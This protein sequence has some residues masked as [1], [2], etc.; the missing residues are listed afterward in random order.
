MENLLL[1]DLTTGNIKGSSSSGKKVTSDSN[2]NLYIQ[3]NS[4]SKSNY[5]IIKDSLNAFFL[6][7]VN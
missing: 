1:A 7:S 2:L 5:V 4:M 3:K 6:S